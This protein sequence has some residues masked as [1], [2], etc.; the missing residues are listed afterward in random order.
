MAAS[1]DNGDE[2][3]AP[4]PPVREV[5]PAQLRRFLR[6]GHIFSTAVHEIL[7]ARYLSEVTDEPLTVSQLNLLKLIAAEDD[8]HVG[9]VAGLLGVS[10]PA[11]SKNIDKLATRGLV[12]RSASADDR[13]LTL[14]S[15]SGKGRRLV[16][17]YESLQAARLAPALGAMASDEID[18][19]TD[20]LE[21][22][23]LSL[24]SRERPSHDFCLR[25]AAYGAQDCAIL[26]ISGS[27]PYRRG[28]SARAG[29]HGI[30]PGNHPS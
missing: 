13:R 9:E 7:E 8:R 19:L 6:C 22:F 14:L 17:R 25:C 4:V 3:R 27:C 29:P 18:Q 23:A 28:N 11:V 30:E 15:A 5:P 2:R 12:R 20:L 26:P 16:R 21:R 1:A 24:Y 10:S